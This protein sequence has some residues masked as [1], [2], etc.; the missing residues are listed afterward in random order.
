MFCTLFP[1]VSDWGGTI[2]R[3]HMLKQSVRA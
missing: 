2:E 1:I 3:L